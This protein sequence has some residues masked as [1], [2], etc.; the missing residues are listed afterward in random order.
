MKEKFIKSAIILL[1]GGAITKLL[2]MI[3]KMTQTRLIGVEGIGIY[4]LII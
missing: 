1:I 4:S 3:I 2:G